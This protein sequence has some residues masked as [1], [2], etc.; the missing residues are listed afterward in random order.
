[1]CINFQSNFPTVYFAISTLQTN[2][3]ILKLSHCL[4]SRLD[5]TITFWMIWSCYSCLSVFHLLNEGYVRP[6]QLQDWVGDFKVTLRLPP[7]RSGLACSSQI[8]RFVSN[9]FVVKWATAL[10]RSESVVSTYF[11]WDWIFNPYLHQN[12]VKGK[13]RR[14]GGQEICFS[15]TLPQKFQDELHRYKLSRH[16]DVQ[17]I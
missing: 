12:N 10:T 13:I 5:V 7:P 2:F 17:R 9:F 8:V 14:W 6:G 1:M 3:C 16:I 15:Q 11:F 4:Q